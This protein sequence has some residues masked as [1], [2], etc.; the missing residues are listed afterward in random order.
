TLTA[1]TPPGALG[2]ANVVVTTPAGGSAPF[3]GFTYAPM[4]TVT[5]VVVTG[6]PPGTPARG[7]TTG[8]TPLTIPGTDFQ[9]GARVFLGGLPSA[10]GVEATDVL[11]TPPTQ[12]TANTPLFSLPLHRPGGTAVVV[13]NPDGQSGSLD[14]GFDYFLGPA[15]RIIRTTPP[16]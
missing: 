5:S 1:T 12:I 4:P 6:T 10:N 13:L 15:P 8:G 7:P 11:V 16:S 9:L 3:R 2:P 14:P